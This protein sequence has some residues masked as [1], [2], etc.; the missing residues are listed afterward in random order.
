MHAI[1]YSSMHPDGKRIAFQDGDPSSLEIWSLDG[2]FRAEC[3]AAPRR[4]ASTSGCSHARY[5]PAFFHN[6]STRRFT[7]GVISI[8]SGQRRLKPSPRH[9][10]VASIP[11]LEP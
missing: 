11:I 4:R 10:L 9:F 1:R 7:S 8:T 2:F 3:G 5:S 6:S